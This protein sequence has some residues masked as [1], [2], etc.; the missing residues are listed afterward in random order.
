MSSAFC[1]RDTLRC[2][3]RVSRHS[4]RVHPI[5][6]G[7][8]I[9]RS[10]RIQAAEI[11]VSVLKGIRPLALH[12]KSQN[13]TFAACCGTGL[14]LKVVYAFLHCTLPF[15]MSSDTHHHVV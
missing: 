12:W 6:V 1:D 3:D 10:P 2:E 7:S 4:V 13:D 8:N 14:P 9:F 15:Y 11:E 5:Q